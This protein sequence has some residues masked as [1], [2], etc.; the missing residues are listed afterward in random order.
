MNI[1]NSL[2]DT[3]K[4]VVILSGGMDSTIAMRFC[5]EKY[6]ANNVYAL[7]FDYNQKQN[8]EIEKA[9][10]STKLLGVEHKILDLTVLGNL[11]QGFSANVDKTI[12]MPSIKDV[13]GDPTP[14]TYVPNRN[15]ILMSLAAAYAETKNIEYIICGLQVHDE[16]GYWDTTKKF[17]N[18][19]N[20]VFSENRKIKIK[21]IA[22]FSDLSKTE[23]LQL[24][25]KIDNNINLTKHTL[26][27][28]NPNEIHESCGVC[29][30]C[31]E[32]IRAFMNI[33]I[34][35]PIQYSKNIKWSV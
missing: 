35:D 25:L 1:L 23:E 8:V 17:V 12:D 31:S 4:V 9:K 20:D 14:K 32:R 22:P 34:K 11:S 7:T 24:L 10:E 27:C 6:G 16:Y 26:T 30:S 33:G 5:V 18:S 28:Y 15:M 3:N 13:L 2:P 21:L 29:P 19:M